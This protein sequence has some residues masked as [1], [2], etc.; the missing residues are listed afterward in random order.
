METLGCS[1]CKK[2]LSG[3]FGKKIFAFLTEKH[4]E[5]RSNGGS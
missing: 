2:K 5:K 1:K 4:G 3:G